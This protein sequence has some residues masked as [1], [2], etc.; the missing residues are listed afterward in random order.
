MEQGTALVLAL[1]LLALAAIAAALL[2]Y[3]LCRLRPPAA[4]ASPSA[5]AC[6]KHRHAAL[7]VTHADSA[8]GLQMALWLASRGFRVFAGLKDPEGDSPAAVACRAW[9]KRREGE[10][11]EEGGQGGWLQALRLDACREDQLH[12]AAG[13]VRGRLPAAEDGLW[14]VVHAGGGGGACRGR[15]ESQQ[16]AQWEQ[17]LREH[18][19]GSLRASRAL[20][21]LLRSQKGRLLLLGSAAEAGGAA[22]L[23]A[24]SA[25]RAAVEGAADALRAEVAPVR[26]ITLRPHP[27]L[28]PE[29]LFAPP[30]WRAKSESESD[31]AAVGDAEA[32]VG[33]RREEE[34]QVVEC[35]VLAQDTLLAI[36]DAL[37]CASPKHSY[38]LR[39]H[40]PNPPR[41]SLFARILTHR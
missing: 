23:V 9:R 17:L 31:A 36:E 16:S 5:T 28:P 40:L 20:L 29:A 38:P 24:W 32:G 13:F 37:L 35:S 2:L 25:A 41:T 27:S 3:L 33:R 10:G 22:G 26:V 39:P 6:C 1:Q 4:S 19:V 18:V 11:A 7:L 34:E 30:R 21:P 12:D 15:L 8:L 14:G